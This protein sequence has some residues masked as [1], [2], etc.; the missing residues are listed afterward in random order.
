MLEEK[1]DMNEKKELKKRTKTNEDRM[2]L[3]R[4][5]KEEKEKGGKKSVTYENRPCSENDAKES[6]AVERFYCIFFLIQ[7]S[8]NDFS[9]LQIISFYS[10]TSLFVC[11]YQSS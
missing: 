1:K 4:R 2:E 3:W 11:K 6:D 5:R 9:R 7:K 10:F 8:N